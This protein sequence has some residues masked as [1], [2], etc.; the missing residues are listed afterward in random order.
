MLAS[1][2]W[3]QLMGKGWKMHPWSPSSS[4]PCGCFSPLMWCLWGG[5]LDAAGETIPCLCPARTSP[6]QGW[7]WWEPHSPCTQGPVLSP[8]AA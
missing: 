1:L 6:G 4:W 8:A 2:A 7:G 5:V 3:G